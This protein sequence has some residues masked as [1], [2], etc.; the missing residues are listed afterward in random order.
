M[1]KPGERILELGCG[2]GRALRPVAEAV[3]PACVVGV[4]RSPVMCG[5]A[6]RHNRS[7]IDAGRVRVERGDSDRSSPTGCAWRAPARRR[8]HER[9][10]LRHCAR[11]PR[12]AGRARGVRRPGAVELV[13]VHRG[14]P[15]SAEVLD[16]RAV[17]GARHDGPA[18]RHLALLGRR[19]RPAGGAPVRSDRH[20]LGPPP[21]LADC[22]GDPGRARR[23]RG[24]G[25]AAAAGRLRAH[26][27][28]GRRVQRA[29]QRARRGALGRLPRP[30]ARLRRQG[31]RRPHR[32]H[33]SGRLA[34]GDGARRRPAR[35]GGLRGYVGRRARR[36][37]HAGVGVPAAVPRSGHR[38]AG[39][40]RPGREHPRDDS[41]PYPCT[42]CSVGGVAKGTLYGYVESK[43]ALFALCIFH[44]DR[45]GAMERPATLPV[46]TP[47]RGSCPRS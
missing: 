43:E 25:P 32:H 24:V 5:V 17:D 13:P 22:V 9:A 27:L 10:R 29:V 41:Q 3:A 8:A 34:A 40:P 44:A 31:V 1:P 19:H 37:P 35:R 11:R 20:A 33:R 36:H 16:G 30:L 7:A 46:P 6:R 18:V 38:A 47:K 42:A 2:H 12:T 23:L 15:L 28:D 14:E 21:A 39:S 45:S 4:D 26:A